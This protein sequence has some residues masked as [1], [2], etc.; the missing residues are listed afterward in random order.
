MLRNRQTMLPANAIALGFA[1]DRLLDF[2]PFPRSCDAI[3]SFV[4]RPQERFEAASEALL[5][6]IT[7]FLVR[8]EI[9]EV[10]HAHYQS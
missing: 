3:L 7:L 2:Q 1:A 6:L 5:G 10:R 8:S 9:L 4:L